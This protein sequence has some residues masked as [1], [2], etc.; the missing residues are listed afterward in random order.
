MTYVFER[1]LEDLVGELVAGAATLA[2]V[3]AHVLQHR[4]V[5]HARLLTQLFLACRAIQQ[6][7]RC[8]TQQRHRRAAH[9]RHRRTTQE[10]HRRAAQSTSLN[11]IKAAATLGLGYRRQQSHGHLSA[12]LT[13]EL[14]EQRLF[15]GLLAVTPQLVSTASLGRRQ[16]QCFGQGALGWCPVSHT[17]KKQRTL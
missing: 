6:Y 9:Q 10:R 1:R 13:V 5:A 17:G 4:Q 12:S 14:L 7:H 3:V 8:V 11:H 16:R 15:D 2:R